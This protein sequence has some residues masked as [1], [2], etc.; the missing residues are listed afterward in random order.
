[1]L[2]KERWLSL[3][4]GLV[5]AGIVIASYSTGLFAGP[6]ATIEDTQF[7]SRPTS[8]Q[9]VIVA[10]DDRSIESVGQWP[11]PRA[12]FAKLLDT[13]APYQ[14]Q[15]VSIDVLFT[16]PSRLG[17][18]DDA[19]L[20]RA[21]ERVPFPVVLAS[22]AQSLALD[23]EGARASTLLRPLPALEKSASAIGLVNVISD[24]DGIVRRFAEP[25][26]DTQGVPF[27]SFAGAVLTAS[28]HTDWASELPSINRI[29]YAGPPGSVR[30]ISAA[31][32]LSGTSVDDLRNKI[33]FVG[34]TAESL[35]DSQKTPMSGGINMPGV[36]IHAQIANMLLLDYRL[37]P[38][39]T[40]AT[41]LWIVL[42]S[43]IAVAILLFVRRFESAVALNIGVGVVYIILGVVLFERGTEV[44]IIHI[45]LAWI[46]VA[47]SLSLYR[48]FSSE[49]ERRIIRHT[50]SKY[51]APHVL[52]E[53]LAHPERI[54][55]G[56]E[57]REITVLFSDIRGFTTLS[58]NTTPTELVRILNTYFSAVTKKIIE[59]DGVL[60]KYIGDAIMAFWGAPIENPRQ[61]DQAV[62]A[63]IEMLR[64]LEELNR[65]FVANGDPEIKIGIGIYTGRAVVGNIGSEHRFDYTVIGDTVNAASRLEGLTKEFKTQIIIGESTKHKLT[66]HFSLTPLGDTS[67]KGKVEKI[68]IY[69]VA[70]D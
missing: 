69:G 31:D 18:P 59:N 6:E 28:G 35:H 3:S 45:S 2:T 10:I 17:N 36:E 66:E 65:T 11:W 54:A 20:A 51:V 43:C 7:S 60:D 13:L 41:M 27:H 70:P 37:V 26:L 62:R 38:L 14:P 25:M 55:L 30:T 67:V 50:F 53:L 9:I 48:F 58:E 49:K 46:V 47:T 4:I 61:A 63:G 22:Q 32:V 64:A 33:I 15:V 5:G 24:R 8:P 57:E 44:N 29:V 21:L 34:A 56:G 19:A 42:A 68:T 1:M 23:K 52:D 12:T 39:S 40:G 16:E